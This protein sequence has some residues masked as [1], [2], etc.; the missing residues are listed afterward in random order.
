MTARGVAAGRYATQMSAKDEIEAL[1][2]RNRIDLPFPDPFGE[3]DNV[4]QF[5]DATIYRLGDVEHRLDGPALRRDCGITIWYRNGIWH[6][7]GGPAFF[8]KSPRPTAEKYRHVEPARD[9]A[10][11]PAGREQWLEAWFE[12]GALHREDRKS[13]RLNSSHWE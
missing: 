12:N 13:T 5:S 3:Y 9:G 2:A 1:Y 10:P 7:S 8:R 11:R 4:L 6:R